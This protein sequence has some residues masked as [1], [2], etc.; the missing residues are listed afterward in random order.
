MLLE[1]Y[2]NECPHCVRMAPLVER[3]KQEEG[4]T[5]E[6]FEVWHDDDNSIKMDEYDTGLCGGVPFF[7]NTETKEFICGSTSYEDLCAWA[8]GEKRPQRSG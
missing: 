7:F 8:K 3:L 4:I 2:G 5:V 1:F 6:Q